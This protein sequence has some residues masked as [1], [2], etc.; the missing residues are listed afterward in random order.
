[1]P[2]RLTGRSTAPKHGSRG[3]GFPAL[4]VSAKATRGSLTSVQEA[5]SPLRE[6]RDGDRPD[7]RDGLPEGPDAL[8]L[9]KGIGSQV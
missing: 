7:D 8:D 2:W 3:K 9:V 6:R 4:L 1:M 5:L